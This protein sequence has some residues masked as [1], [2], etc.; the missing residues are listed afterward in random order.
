M[1]ALQ[2]A[3]L[4][5]RPVMDFFDLETPIHSVA[6]DPSGK[7]VAAGAEDGKTAVWEV[8]SGTI[9]QMNSFDA[10]SQRSWCSAT[11]SAQ[12]GGMLVCCTSSCKHMVIIIMML[13]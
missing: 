10:R 5:P 3:G 11:S 12:R 13:E 7:L 9:I 4:D 1:W 8:H 2:E 6:I